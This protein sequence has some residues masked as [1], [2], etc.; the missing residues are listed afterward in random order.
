[1]K[2]YFVFFALIF[3]FSST[4][5]QEKQDSIKEKENP[6]VF[7]D[8][9]LGFSNTGK[10]AVT[11]GFTVNYQLKNDLFT[12][13][14]NQTTSIDRI[15]WFLFIPVSV[16]SNTTTEIAALYGKR[17]IEDG[18]SYHFSGGISYN[19]NKDVNGVIKTSNT[20][21]GFPLE[22]GMSLFKSKKERFRVFYGLIPVGEPTSFGRS[23]GFKLYA[24]IAK[25]SYV[26]LGLTFGLGWHKIYK[27]EK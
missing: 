14:A 10:S 15:D 2:N 25:K 1:L 18:L 16:V 22:I 13:R 12:F 17:Y 27:N 5:A 21:A 11:T 7:G 26:G 19:I 3:A 24:N 8:F 4:I 9:L 20:F 23:I 6:I